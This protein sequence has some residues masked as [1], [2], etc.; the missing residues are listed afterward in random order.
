MTLKYQRPSLQYPKQRKS[1][2]ELA[3]LCLDNR[4]HMVWKLCMCM[5]ARSSCW[6]AEEEL[7]SIEGK[8]SSKLIG[9]LTMPLPEV[10]HFIGF[11]LT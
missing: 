1:N 8:R 10:V 11:Y 7:T 9:S 5:H 2:L 4:P 3:Q 6:P